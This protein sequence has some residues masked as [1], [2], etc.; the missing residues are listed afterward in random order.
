M[1]LTSLPSSRER[2]ASYG[3]ATTES[4]A[5]SPESTSKFSRPAMPTVTGT[6]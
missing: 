2:I 6:K 5:D 4:P 1:R 3:P